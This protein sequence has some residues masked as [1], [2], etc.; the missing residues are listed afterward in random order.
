MIALVCGLVSSGIVA[1]V[2]A[3]LYSDGVVQIDADE[4]FE[5]FAVQARQFSDD[6][7]DLFDD[8]FFDNLPEF[9]RSGHLGTPLRKGA[10]SLLLSLL[11]PGR[12][13]VGEG[14]AAV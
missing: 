9:V 10:P 5:S 14:F 11:H 2:A 8:A 13:R 7:E 3:G 4:A 12:C 1:A 6:V